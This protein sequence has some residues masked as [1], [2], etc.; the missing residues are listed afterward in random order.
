MTGPRVLRR[1]AA[2]LAAASF[3][4]A[5]GLTAF[6]RDD[7]PPGGVLA[8]APGMTQTDLETVMGPPSYI[9]VRYY[10]AG[11]AVLPEAVDG[12]APYRTVGRSR[13]LRHGLV[14]QLPRRAHARLPE[15]CTWAAARTSSPPSAGKTSK[16][17][18]GLGTLGK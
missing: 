8:I 3:V 14:S 16:A 2:L 15:P 17:W 4:C 12:P 13:H 9:Q 1:I 18:A 10:A 7:E 11:L 5:F 6:A